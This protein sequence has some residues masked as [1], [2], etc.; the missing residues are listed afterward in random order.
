MNL[1]TFSLVDAIGLATFALAWLGYAALVDHGPL[2]ERTL[3]HA[4]DRQ[5]RVWVEAMQGREVRLGDVNL[6]AGLQNGTAFF[7]SASMLAI[8]AGLALLG[9]G[10]RVVGAVER[11]APAAAGGLALFEGKLIGLIVIFVYAFFKF[12]WSYRLFNYAAI[13]V[14]ALPSA[15]RAGSPEARLAVDRTTLF[16]RLAGRHFNRGQRAFNFAVA[17]LG[18]FAGP[19]VLIGGTLVVLAVLLHRQFWSDSARAVGG[20]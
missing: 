12:G 13:L 11:I 20:R 7:A 19:W 10:E 15:G 6:L 14:G 3:S 18:W 1:S 8:G 4:I 2:A 9:S 16:I 17:W 5:R